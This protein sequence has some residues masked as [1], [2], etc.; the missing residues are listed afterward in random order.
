VLY[1][2]DLQYY[3]VPSLPSDWEA[4]LWLRTKLGIYS[5]H[6]YFEYPEYKSLLEYLGVREKTGRIRE[7]EVD[8]V[9][10]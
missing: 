2:S 7:D 9:G 3:A 6:L 5:G 10:L 1:F 8:D 4:P